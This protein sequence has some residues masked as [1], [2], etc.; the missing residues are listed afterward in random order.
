MAGLNPA[1][2]LC[3]K[4]GAVLRSAKLFDVAEIGHRKFVKIERADGAGDPA[5]AGFR[6]N[7][8]HLGNFYRERDRA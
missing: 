3:G 4:R 8:A 6:H 7:A 1:M 2:E 5:I